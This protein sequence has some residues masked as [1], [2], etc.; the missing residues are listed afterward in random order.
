MYIFFYNDSGIDHTT[1]NGAYQT[2]GK[3]TGH[4]QVVSIQAG[5]SF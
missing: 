4:A 2:I 5:I 3:Y 1:S